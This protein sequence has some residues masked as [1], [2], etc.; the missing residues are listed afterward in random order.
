MDRRFATIRHCWALYAVQPRYR[1]KRRAQTRRHPIVKH[2]RCMDHEAA[3]SEA[4]SAPQTHERERVTRLGQ[5]V[6]RQMVP[7][8]TTPVRFA[9]MRLAFVRLAFVRLAFVRLASL[10]TASV[11]FAP[12]RFAPVRS[13]PE[14]SAP[15][16]FVEDIFAPARLAQHTRG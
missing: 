6:N 11:R 2:F 1:S 12:V 13:T 9:S 8:I 16:R 5:V 10:R 15:V 14:R 7:V 4:G 3:V